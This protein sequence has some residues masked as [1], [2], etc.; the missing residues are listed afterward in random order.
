MANQRP[1]LEA[2]AGT[3][4]HVRW[5]SSGLA[6]RLGFGSLQTMVVQSP[7]A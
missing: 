6:P 1:N 7:P 3:R 5:T 2:E 4:S